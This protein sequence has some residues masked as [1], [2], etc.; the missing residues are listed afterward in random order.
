MKKQITGSE[1]FKQHFRSIYNYV[2]FRVGNMAD[3]EDI[4]STVMEKI[5]KNLST[6]VPK[7]NATIRS[8]IFAITRNCIADFYQAKKDV[9]DIHSTVLH[10]HSP[11]QEEILDRKTDIL[12]LHNAIAKLPAQQKK[13][14]LLRYKADLSNKE[15][16]SL[17]GINPQ[18]VSGALSKA[19]KKLQ[20]LI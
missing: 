20:S 19:I 2:Y 8:W 18:T 3:A 9:A 5:V 7:K 15:I 13:I 14:V 4:S 1:I 17:L 11:M 6:F 10:D 12:S 16:A